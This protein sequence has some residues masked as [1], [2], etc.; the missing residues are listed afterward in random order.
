MRGTRSDRQAHPIHLWR[1][2][3]RCQRVWRLSG[4]SHPRSQPV[5][6]RERK[7]LQLRFGAEM[8]QADTGK[9]LNLS[10]MRIS[11]LLNRACKKLRAGLLAES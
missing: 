5:V 7:L 9:E 3:S 11:R 6:E 2:F 10:Q 4:P 8:T 1:H